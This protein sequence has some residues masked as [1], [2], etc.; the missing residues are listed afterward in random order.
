MKSSSELL[1]SISAECLFEQ[2]EA[3]QDFFDSKF[4]MDFVVSRTHVHTVSHLLLLTDHCQ[5]TKHSSSAKSHH[6]QLPSH[7]SF[8]YNNPSAEMLMIN[9]SGFSNWKH[10]AFAIQSSPSNK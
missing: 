9:H 4:S 10:L 5:D 7:I 1:L 2:S 3:G 6:T 8:L